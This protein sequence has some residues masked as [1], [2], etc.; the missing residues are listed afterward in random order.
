[1]NLPQ[2]AEFHSAMVRSSGRYRRPFCL[3]DSHHILKSRINRFNALGAAGIA[4]VA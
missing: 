1:M 3:R 4:R 2:D